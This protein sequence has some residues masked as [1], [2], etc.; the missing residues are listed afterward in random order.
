MPELPEVETYVRELEP[1]LRGRT[2]TGVIIRWPRIIAAPT[3][4]AFVR[5]IIGQRFATFGRR[6]KYMRFGLVR[7]NPEEGKE[8]VGD[9]LIVHLRMTGKL[10]VKAGEAEP[11]KHAHAI[12]DLDDGR[13]LHY[14]DPRKFGRIWL[15]PDPEPVFRK[16]GP[17]PLGDAFTAAAFAERLHGRRASIKALLLNQSIVAGVGNIYADEALFLAGVHPAR[18]GGELTSE[19]IARLHVAIR[20]ILAQAIE[21]HGSSLGDSSLQNYQRPGGESGDFQERHRVF[22]R[23]G[24]PCPVCGTP[25]ERVVL[26]QRSTHFCPRCQG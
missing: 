4:D 19:E 7:N 18:P 25:I 2:V 8:E 23:T 11:D 15:V 1:D 5:D 22:Q 16:L 21:A 13:R 14:S 10:Q 17:E 3:P 6:G 12:L 9:T 26:A 24:Q 20:A